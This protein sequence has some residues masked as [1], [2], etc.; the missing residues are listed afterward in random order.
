MLFRKLLKKQSIVQIRNSKDKMCL[1]RCLVLGRSLAIDGAA[2]TTYKTLRDHPTTDQL[3]A[4]AELLE[5]VGLPR[6]ELS[7]EDLEKFEQVS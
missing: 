2:S 5:Q 3:Y 6:T 1:A 7:L 4:A